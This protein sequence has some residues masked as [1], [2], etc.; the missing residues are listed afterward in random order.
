MVNVKV[1]RF[2]GLEQRKS[3]ARHVNF[4]LEILNKGARQD[5]LAH[6]QSSEKSIDVSFDGNLCQGSSQIYRVR[7]TGGIKTPNFLHLRQKFHILL[8]LTLGLTTLMFGF[9]A[10]MARQ[11][12]GI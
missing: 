6:S 1:G 5:A 3:R 11:S 9:L 2:V 12:H 7:F 8:R 10:L 4:S